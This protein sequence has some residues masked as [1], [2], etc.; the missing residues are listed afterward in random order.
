MKTTETVNAIRDA[1]LVAYFILK[2]T[3]DRDT[4][5]LKNR[6]LFDA[7][8]HYSLTCKHLG[9]RNSCFLSEQVNL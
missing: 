4:E 6:F 2:R 3:L 8:F 5:L 1:S 9:K 7:Y